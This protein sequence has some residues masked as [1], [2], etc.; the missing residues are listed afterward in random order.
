MS[1]T[2][3]MF[4]IIHEN[5]KKVYSEKIKK[6]KKKEVHKK[7]IR[8]VAIGLIAI[9]IIIT[10]I[11]AFNEREVGRCIEAGHSEEFCRYAGE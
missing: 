8:G 2:N 6:D 10:L 5:R 11:Y 9:T 4:D 1:E 7:S 3:K